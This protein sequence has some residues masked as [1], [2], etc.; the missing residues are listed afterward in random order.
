[1]KNRELDDMRQEITVLIDDIKYQSDMLTDLE[2][3]P[4]LQLK[5][6]LAK[7]SK[8]T[9]KTTILLH[10]VEKKGKLSQQVYDNEEV[11]EIHE[12]DGAPETFADE[13]A[14]AEAMEEAISIPEPSKPKVEADLNKV[15]VHD[16]SA[17]IGINEKYLYASELYGG[18][19]EALFASIKV[20]NEL[21]DKKALGAYIED[22]KKTYNW[23][24]ESQTVKNFIELVE[25]KFD[26][27]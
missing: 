6:L 2:R 1:M 5:V 16:L 3:L 9:E 17:A 22:L 23:N 10:Y 13:D 14:V 25:R 12:I 11:E 18:S 4:V 7:I 15:K 20:I 26:Q 21:Q 27:P 8:M 24:P 19:T